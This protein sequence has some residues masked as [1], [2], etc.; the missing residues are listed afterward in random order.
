MGILAEAEVMEPAK[1]IAPVVRSAVD[2]ALAKPV[3]PIDPEDA[4]Q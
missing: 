1:L 3:L 2:D 4:A